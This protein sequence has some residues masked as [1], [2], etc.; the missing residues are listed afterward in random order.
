MAYA[1]PDA[2]LTAVRD[3][4][5]SAAG[6]VLAVDVTRFSGDLYDG[7]LDDEESRRALVS[8]RAEARITAWEPHGASPLELAT[9]TIYATEVSISVVRHLNQAHKLIDATRDAAKAL[10]AQDADALAQ[11]LSYV[12]NVSEDSGSNATGIISGRLRF[13]GSDI[14]DVELDDDGPGLIRSTH[15]FSGF[16]EVAP[17]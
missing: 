11:A 6:S 13:E 15:R 14:G 5:E 3:V 17:A 16:I 4:I 2:I 1:N 7:L 8:P 10:A 12:G 9:R